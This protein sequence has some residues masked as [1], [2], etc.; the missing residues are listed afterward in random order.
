MLTL[1]NAITRAAACLALA[2]VIFAAVLLTA[3]N[4]PNTTAR[5]PK[6]QPNMPADVA[7]LFRNAYA[8]CK[9]DVLANEGVGTIAAYRGRAEA[10][11]SAAEISGMSSQSSQVYYNALLKLKKFQPRIVEIE[12]GRQYRL[13]GDQRAASLV[14]PII[15]RHINAVFTGIAISP[16]D[17]RQDFESQRY[18]AYTPVY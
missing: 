9:L 7:T 1:T 3:C 11:A 16:A 15:L 18:R 12:V 17:I 2:L 13:Q 5:A 8:M 6:P 10:D 14:Q 4:N